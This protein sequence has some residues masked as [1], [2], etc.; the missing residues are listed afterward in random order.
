MIT[1]TFKSNN[2]AIQFLSVLERAGIHGELVSLSHAGNEKGCSYGVRLEKAHV[3]EAKRA[4]AAAG[5]RPE[6]WL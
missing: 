3:G 1:A 6:K 4:A 2:K 5:V